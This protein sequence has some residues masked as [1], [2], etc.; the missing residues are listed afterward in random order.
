MAFRGRS[1]NSDRCHDR[2]TI[3]TA[4][5]MLLQRPPPYKRSVTRWFYNKNMSTA[6]GNRNLETN[7]EQTDRQTDNLMLT[8]R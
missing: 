5:S 4:V 6:I 3:A 8:E 2:A 1:V 7:K